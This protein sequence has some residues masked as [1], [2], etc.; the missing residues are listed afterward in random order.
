M[1]AVINS[2]CRPWKRT[3]AKV[4]IADNSRR[5]IRCNCGRNED[6]IA[7]EG[8]KAT[9]DRLIAESGYQHGYTARWK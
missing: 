1:P 5:S 8:K 3:A 4:D 9:R 7:A 6:A 2:F